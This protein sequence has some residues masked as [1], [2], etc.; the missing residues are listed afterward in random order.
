MKYIE[1]SQRECAIVKSN[2]VTPATRGISTCSFLVVFHP[3]NNTCFYGHVD[4]NTDLS[5]IGV[6]I[7]GLLP[8]SGLEAYI[9]YDSECISAP[10]KLAEIL[11]SSGIPEPQITIQDGDIIQP[12][13]EI[14]FGSLIIFDTESRQFAFQD[15]NTKTDKGPDYYTRAYDFTKN[16]K[17]ASNDSLDIIYDSRRERNDGWTCKY[18]VAQESACQQAITH[19]RANLR[20]Q[21]QAYGYI[22]EQISMPE[23][24][25]VK[26]SY[27]Q[28]GIDISK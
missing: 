8:P 24:E 3:E 16:R 18:G 20:G 10:D 23:V 9:Y 13:M 14:R 2:E 7:R 21:L 28:S 22:K 11:V 6:Q 19:Y 26:A 17:S 15:K 12:D 5:T 27:I 25:L 1:V 4:G